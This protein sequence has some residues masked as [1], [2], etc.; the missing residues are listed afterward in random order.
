MISKW[1]EDDKAFDFK[2]DE[3]A[4]DKIKEAVRGIRN[5]VSYTHLDGYKR[6]GH[7]LAYL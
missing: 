5:A 1:P 4:G 3:A 2:A 7:M 6:Q